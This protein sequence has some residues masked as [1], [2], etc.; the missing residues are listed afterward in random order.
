MIDTINGFY[1]MATGLDEDWVLETSSSKAS[2]TQTTNK[3][4]P[5][6]APPSITFVTAAWGAEK[7]NPTH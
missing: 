4:L 1:L 7:C 2:S 6:Y 3:S 5:Q